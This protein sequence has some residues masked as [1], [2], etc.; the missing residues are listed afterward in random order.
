MSDFDETFTLPA[1]TVCH[2]HGIPFALAQDAQIRTHPNNH[3]LMLDP[4]L[5]SADIQEDRREG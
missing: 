2:L 3:K 1:G 4:E 5:V